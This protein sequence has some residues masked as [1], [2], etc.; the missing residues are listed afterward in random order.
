M[1]SLPS[2]AG[3]AALE[4][5]LFDVLSLFVKYQD[6]LQSVVEPLKHGRFGVFESRFRLRI[7]GSAV[8]EFSADMFPSDLEASTLVKLHAPSSRN[9][10]ATTPVMSESADAGETSVVRAAAATACLGNPPPVV[11]DAGDLPSPQRIV[12]RL[13]A[14]APL[15]RAQKAFCDVLD[16]VV[17]A[18]GMKL[19][20]LLRLRAHHPAAWDQGPPRLPASGH[21]RASLGAST[22]PAPTSAS[23]AAAAA[24]AA[25]G[26]S[27]GGGDVGADTSRVSARG[28]DGDGASDTDGSV[29][30]DGDG[31]ESGPAET[32]ASTAGATGD[33][34]DDTGR[35]AAGGSGLRRRRNR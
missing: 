8:Q 14:S 29:D 18:A 28:S 6:T 15:L 21:A 24:A 27:V 32:A 10:G 19:A 35:S 20:M 12:R 1:T 4:S 7:T 9:H 3:N 34:A 25:A 16:A 33:P 13:N 31:G 11:L 26:Q 23:A 5:T 30:A 2:A 22:A 17:A